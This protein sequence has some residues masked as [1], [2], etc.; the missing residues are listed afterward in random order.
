MR[1]LLTTTKSL[2]TPMPDRAADPEV[3]VGGASEGGE[4]RLQRRRHVHYQG[5]DGEG[6]RGQGVAAVQAPDPA[7]ELIADGA[8]PEGVG[9]SHGGEETF[10][11]MA[12]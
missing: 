7:G 2:T 9:I 4:R 6:D 1:Y 11:L 3:R 10:M 5:L 12:V 8:K